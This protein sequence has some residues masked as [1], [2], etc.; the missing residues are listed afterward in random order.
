[1]R[2]EWTMMAEFITYLLQNQRK[3]KSIVSGAI[4]VKWGCGLERIKVS[5]TWCWESSRAGGEGAKKDEVVGWHHWLSG[6]EFEQILGASERQGSLVC[7]SPW[8]RKEL[9]TN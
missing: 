2:V 5:T 3:G 4:K 6:H 8:D 1:M 7:C 9:D